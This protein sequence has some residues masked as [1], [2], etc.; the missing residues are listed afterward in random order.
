MFSCK[1]FQ[2]GDVMKELQSDIYNKNTLFISIIAAC[3][4]EYYYEK[5]GKEAKV[6]IVNPNLPVK[7]G[8]GIVAVLY[9]E[10]IPC[11]DKLGKTIYVKT[12]EDLNK[13]TVLTGSGTGFVYHILDAYLQTFEQMDLQ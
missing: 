4:R 9:E 10:R 2:I 3:P 8:M 1:P 5:L 13:F 12:M 11:L 7:I 6:A